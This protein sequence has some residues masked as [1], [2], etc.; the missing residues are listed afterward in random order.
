MLELKQFELNVTSQN[1][2]DG[3]LSEILKRLSISRGVCIEFGAWDGKHLSNTWDLWHNRKWKALLIEGD[4]EKFAVLVSKTGQFEN[5]TAACRYVAISGK[6]TLDSIVKDCAFPINIDLLSIDIDG[7]D[8]SIFE[9]LSELHSK[10]VVIEFNSTF[11]HKVRFRQ[12]P[13]SSIGSSAGAVLE[14][15]KSRGY[16]LAHITPT[17]LILVHD[18]VFGL[19]RIS[20]PSLADDFPDCHQSHI[21]MS[22]DGQAFLLRERLPHQPARPSVSVKRLLRMILRRL[23]LRPRPMKNKELF[24]IDVVGSHAA[25]PVQQGPFPD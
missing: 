13:G 21:V 15:A 2:E 7:D 3:V 10:I 4:P 1:G 17:N 16:R 24:P 18:S 9:S 5:V 8:L 20:E 14:V 23:F 25:L 22:Y 12:S 11:P 6:D 19:L